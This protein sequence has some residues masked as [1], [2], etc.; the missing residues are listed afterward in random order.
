MKFEKITKEDARCNVLLY[1]KYGSG[2]T[3]TALSLAS[4]LA[5]KGKIAVIDTEG[6][7]TAVY[8]DQFAFDAFDASHTND[9]AEYAEAIVEIDREGYDVIILDSISEAWDGDKGGVLAQA[10]ASTNKSQLKWV[11]AKK[12]WG[13][14]MGVMRRTSA[15]IIVTAKEKEVFDAVAKKGTGEL[16]PVME[17]NTPYWFDIVLRMDETTATI[18]K[19]MNAED[20]TVGAQIPRPNQATLLKMYQ[21]A[22]KIQSTKDEPPALQ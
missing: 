15:K 19:L 8:L 4:A 16:A 3:F 14:L 17:K 18:E 13:V 22:L 1:G 10:A 6:K 20:K 21:R 12:G 7:R 9:P 2:K 5:P 11:E